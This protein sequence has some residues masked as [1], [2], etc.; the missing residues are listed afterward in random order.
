[1]NVIA[2]LFKMITAMARTLKNIAASFLLFSSN[3]KYSRGSS[4]AKPMRL[5]NAE[6]NTVTAIF[7]SFLRSS[8]CNR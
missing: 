2:T 8:S 3:R 1:M 5:S 4:T 7:M 6:K